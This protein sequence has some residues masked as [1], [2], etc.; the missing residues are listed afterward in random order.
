MRTLEIIMTHWTEPWEVGRKFFDMLSLQRGVDF[1]R[2]RVTII[3][4]GTEMFPADR[5]WEYPYEI[6]QTEVPHGGIS[7][8]RNSGIDYADARWIQFCDFDDMYSG[9]YSLR[10]VLDCLET[11]DYDILW[12]EFYAEDRTKDGQ[13]IIN[14]R[15]ENVVFIHGKYFRTEWL[16]SSG[17]RFDPDLSFNE[18]SAFC[19]IASLMIPKERIGKIDHVP[20]I[21]VWCYRDGSATGSK[22]NKIQAMIGSYQRNRKVCD[23]YRKYAAGRRHAMMCARLICDAYWMFCLEKLPEQLKP[24]LEDFRD[25]YMDNETA[26]GSIRM[27]D[28]QE[29]REASRREHEI[30]VYEEE[31]RWGLDES[32]THRDIGISAWL[33]EIT[34]G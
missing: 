29:V 32:M 6:R 2:I 24:W 9:A 19:T 14:K 12:G 15:G 20:P 8:A 18:D 34:E 3:H 23:A 7:E 13:T 5:F 16:K 10:T 22:Q 30:S 11:D 26:F 17:L 31:R 33:K 25:W 27:E 21:Y 4:D 1:S 28:L